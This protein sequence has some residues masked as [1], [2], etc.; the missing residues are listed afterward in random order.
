MAVTAEALPA[1]V[2]AGAR[3]G[4]RPDLELIAR[5]VA[6]GSR[7]LDV[8]SGNGELLAYLQRERRVDGRGIEI[9]QAGVNA[10]VAQGLSV[11]QG[12]ADTD[13]GDYPT[14]AFD[15]V[16]LSLTLQATR[17][18]KAVLAELLRIGRRAIISF[19]N[20]GYWKVRFSLA[21]HGRM[22]MTRALDD[23]WWST[24]N[25]HL[26][27]IRDFDLLCAEMGVAVE[28][29]IAVSD[30]G[31]RGPVRAPSFLANLL[32]EKAVYLLSRKGRA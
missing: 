20:F 12:D 1:T 3:P 29:R 23:P 25:I 7:V 21:W 24:P 15:Y 6:P 14:G 27:T 28:Q 4:L 31:P 26:C 16:I 18:P 8:G 22:P 19:P 30:R 32:G 10:C 17:N 9:R 13:L 2:P 11:I 5:M